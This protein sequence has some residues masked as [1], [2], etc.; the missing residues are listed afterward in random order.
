MKYIL[1]IG[2]ITLITRSALLSQ[3]VDRHY[4]PQYMWTTFHDE[5]SGPALD[6]KQWTTTTHFKRG[7]G[8]LIDSNQ[9]IQFRKGNLLLKMKRTPNYLD[10]IWN[11]KGWQHVLSDY[12]GGEVTTKRKF[13]Y[14]SFECKA[15]Y[16]MKRGAWPAFWLIGSSG[17][18]C[19]PGSDG[20]EIDIA[21]LAREGDHPLMMH[22]IHRYYPPQNCDVSIQK[23]M[24]K[25]IYPIQ[26][27]QKYS[28]FK[29][30][31]TPERIQ[32]Y[33]DNQ[34]KHEVINN[35]YEWFPK[36]PLSLIL[37]Q[38][39]LQA[40]DMYGEIKPIAPQ[41]SRFD[42]V[43][44]KEFFLA[45]EIN[46]PSSITQQ[47]TATLDVDSRAANISWKLTPSSLFTNSE[48]KG[49]TATITR[50]V[51]SNAAGKIIYTFNMPSGEVFTVE[52]QF[53]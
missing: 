12:V 20:N 41:T 50:A 25:K 40:Y 46:C 45:P 52:K 37:S 29:C 21:E 1:L 42:W 19:P 9:T 39:V 30:I 18:P 48:G 44:V 16:A 6:R 23:N 2:L 31:W 33:I 5:F 53:D 8:F 26:R 38:Q 32:Y 34:L 43:K 51:N 10:S 4:N 27:R 11:S 7:L 3:T 28:T 49:K 17:A 36:L 24:D 14:G 13:Q 15:K 47:A 35:N 22:M